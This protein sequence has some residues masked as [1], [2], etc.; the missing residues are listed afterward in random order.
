MKDA[1]AVVAAFALLAA[2]SAFGTWYSVGGEAGSAKVTIVEQSFG[3]T[4]FEVTVPGV[5]V[6]V[7]VVKGEEFSRVTLPG[8][9]FAV[10]EQGKP[11]VPKV[12]VLLA[13][14]TGA[15]VSAR[16]LSRESE[17]F[18]VDNI[19]PLQ[20]PL[21]E[22]EKPGPLVLDREF[23]SQEVSYPGLDARV[24]E[25]GRWRDL[26]VANIQVYP[27]Q[28]NPGKGE[29]EVASRIRI[30]VDYSG[31]RYP[32][33]IAEWMISYYGSY[34]D[35]FAEVRLRPETDYTPGCRYLV[36]CHDNYATN[37]YLVD[38]LLGWVKQRGYETRMI[39]KPSFTAAEI[40]DSVSTEYDRHTPAVL[41]FVL[42]VGEYAEV[43]MGSMTGV[44]KSD[45]Y[46]S[47]L[48][49]D[50]YPEVCIARLSPDSVGDLENQIRKVLKYQKDPPATNDWLTKLNM[51]AHS[52]NYPGKYSACI[53]GIYN[54]PKPFYDYDTDTLMGQFVGNPAVKTA[55]ES[56]TGMMI[57]RGHGSTTSWSGWGTSGSWT[58]DNVA[59]LTNG[60]LT[61]VTHHFACNSG[62]IRHG[63]CHIEAWRRKYPGGAVSALSAT[64]PSFTYPN[65]GQCSTVVRA[66]ADTWTITVPGVRDYPG[67]V[68][69]VSG[70][71]AYMDAYLAKYWTGDYLKNIYMYLTLG[72]PSMPVWSG[73]MPQAPDVVYPGVIPLGPY[74]L[75]VTV[76][77]SGRPVQD[78]LVCVWKEPDFYVVERTN[79]SGI[80]QLAT[81]AISP[82]EVKVT[83]S[84]GHAA[85]SQHTPILPHQGTCIAQTG[86]VPYVMYLR[87]TIDDSAGGNNDGCVNPGETVIMPTW[88]KNY[89]DSAAHSLTGKI[90]TGDTYITITDSAKSFGD[91]AGR[92]SAWTGADGY[93]FEVAVSCTNGHL[94]HF[95]M[96]CR[97]ASDSAWLSHIYIRVGAPYLEYAGLGVIDTISGGNGNGRLDPNETAE[98]MTTLHNTGF[99]HASNVTAVLVSGDLRLIVNDSFGSFGQIMADS[100]GTNTDD[101]FKV[102][103]LNMAPETGIPCTLH[104]SAAG[105]FTQVLPFIIVVGEIRA[106]DPIPDGPRMPPLYYAYDDVD[107]L[108]TAHPEFAWVEINTSGTRI[109]YP[110]NDDV[111]VVNLPGGFGPFK[112][113]G[114]RYTQVSVSADGWIAPG[115]YTQTNYTN[116]PLPS[117]SAPPGA[118]ALNWDDLYPGYGSQGYV[119]YYHDAANHRFVVEFD[120]VCYYEQRSIKDKF[121]VI[122][123]DTTLAA[124]DGNSEFTFQYLTAHQPSSAPVGTQDQTKQI[125][126]QCL[127]DGSYHRGSA[128][129]VPG[130]A[131]KFT[132][133]LPTGIGEP[134]RPHAAADR[135]LALAVSPN[136]FHG[137]AVIRWQLPVSGG[138]L[139]RVYDVTGRSVRTLIKGEK[140]AG[141]YN[142]LWDGSDDNGWLVS[143]GTYLYKLETSA[144]VRTTKAVLLR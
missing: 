53:R 115:S 87:H 124:P 1:K 111:I 38:S 64:Q 94:I 134:G 138:V 24:I 60:D 103:T 46:Y 30:R 130:R 125:G 85:G 132:T 31:G 142:T 119:Y 141:S 43:P 127:F 52:Q 56:G 95:N 108:Y 70:V 91:V 77:V 13:I 6:A 58:N 143:N 82:G 120:S 74:T 33:R 139:L 65:H 18:K 104:V 12:S 112:Y 21:L 83:V 41:R 19:Y 36:F 105:G 22:G 2:T 93:E 80:A 122:F 109:N 97:D 25:T 131:I 99:G 121:E 16:V 84:E 34:I 129:V 3:R 54:M 26:D 48:S 133:D 136:P 39:A 76:T 118:M 42:L 63:T 75:N 59:A 17:T 123:Y 68:F 45:F 117:S 116:T 61:P 28:V 10:L 67:P 135:H 29:V 96:E 37:P 110:Q 98:L 7:E 50:N 101:R 8:E 71:M 9:V 20:P 4:T 44:S 35:N 55:V 128:E 89:G 40:K 5:E 114:Q 102:T 107:T 100:S 49:G 144:G 126:I 27:V 88:V 14:P 11:Q 113:Y 92:D 32:A 137:A 47:E 69:P 86:G 90:R 81:N 79:S 72:E 78:A 106:C 15:S 66:V 51:A 23:Y 62:D 140:A 57:Y 73:G